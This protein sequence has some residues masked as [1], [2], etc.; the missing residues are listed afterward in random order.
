[1]QEAAIPIFP[2]GGLPSPDRHT[3]YNDELR[4]GP[5][6]PSRYTRADEQ[7]KGVTMHIDDASSIDGHIRKA[8]DAEFSLSNQIPLPSD[9]SRSIRIVAESNPMAPRAWWKLQLDR[10]KGV[11]NSAADIQ[12]FRNCS[13]PASIRSETWRLQAVA[14]AFLLRTFDLVAR[15]GSNNLHTAST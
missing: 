5:F 15:I 14:L 13:K 2:A 9:V 1:M 12:E 7:M 4:L 10:E 6:H 3:S 11:V 8:I